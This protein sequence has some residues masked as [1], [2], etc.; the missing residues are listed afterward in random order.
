MKKLVIAL[1]ACAFFAACQQKG[2]G[3]V[4]ANESEATMADSVQHDTLVYEGEG[5]AADG[6]YKYTLSLYGDS[7][8]ECAFEEVGI[9]QKGTDTLARTTGLVAF[10]NHGGKKYLRVQEHKEDSLTFL[11]LNDSTLRLVSNDFKEAGSGLNADLKL[12]K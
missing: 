11:Q 1:A 8:N 2:K 3:V 9:T 6:T 4:N 12:K 10:H 7:I 5:P